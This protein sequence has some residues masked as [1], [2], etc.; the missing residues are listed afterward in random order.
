MPALS[1]LYIYREPRCREVDFDSIAAYAGAL[2][3]G[4]EV[5]LRGPLLED[6]I[7]GNGPLGNA[8]PAETIARQMASARV[9]KGY[10]S[11]DMSEEPLSGEVD[12]EIRRLA[13]ASLGVFGILYDAYLLSGLFSELVPADESKIDSLHVVFTN[14]LMGTWDQEDRRYHARAVLCGAPAIVSLSGIVEAPAKARNYYRARRTAEALG[15]SQEEKMELANS[16]AEDCLSLADV[17]LTEVAKGYVMQAVAYRLTAKPFCDDP[18]CRLFNA[19]WQK[20]VLNSQLG[21]ASDF[22]SE[23]RLIFNPSTRRG[24]EPVWI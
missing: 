17:R 22:C 4:T 18:D 13:N 5:F 1:R 21:G 2:L 9:R 3:G 8:V 7:D 23:H 6:S 24:G 19:H 12:Y 16:F 20:E 11:P 15:V 10:I 14:Q